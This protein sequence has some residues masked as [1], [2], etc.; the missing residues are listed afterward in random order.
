MP[1]VFGPAGSST[2][3]PGEAGRV[4]GLAV[5]AEGPA[6]SPW[7]PGRQ[8]GR[9]PLSRVVQRTRRHGGAR[10]PSPTD[11]RAEY[12]EYMIHRHAVAMESGFHESLPARRHGKRPLS[13]R[14]RTACRP[15]AAAGRR[16]ATGGGMRQAGA[17]GRTRT[18]TPGRNGFL[19]PARLPIPPRPLRASPTPAP[20]E[21]SSRARAGRL[22]PRD[23]HAPTG[24]PFRGRGPAAP[25]R[26]SRSRS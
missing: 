8:P 26:R 23:R 1:R 15:G 9:G 25:A 22:R 5:P 3:R 20:E 17:G 19:R 7:R 14:V 4:A 11:S 21:R 2:R 24:C 16:G 6:P 10:P 12:R 18:D 13:G